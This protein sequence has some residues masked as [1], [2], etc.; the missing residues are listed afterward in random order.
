[1]GK[2]K[3]G[4]A[5]LPST[6][7]EFNSHKPLAFGDKA[8]LALEVVKTSARSL[9]AN[10]ALY[11]ENGELSAMMKGAKVTISK[12]LNSAFLNEAAVSD[13]DKALSTGEQP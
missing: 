1:M 2:I 11:H 8:I 12:N 7:G 3:Y 4:A 9:E 10:V 13:K 6:I 5:S